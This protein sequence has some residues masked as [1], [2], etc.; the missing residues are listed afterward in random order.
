MKTFKS[1]T[2]LS[3]ALV[4]G[5]GA[6]ACSNDDTSDV[7]GAGGDNTGG[8]ASGSG[9][10]TNGT[11]GL[12]NLGGNGGEGGAD[13]GATILQLLSADSDYSLLVEAVTAAGLVEALSGNDLTVFAPN[14]AAMEELLDDLDLDSVSDLT[15]AQLRPIL[16]YHVLDH[17][18]SSTEAKSLAPGDGKGTSLG[19]KYELALD[20][21]DLL[22][23][24]ATV[25]MADIQATNGV[26]HHIDSVLLPSITDIVTTDPSLSG[27]KGWIVDADGATD[28]TPKL[29][30]VLDA[31]AEIDGPIDGKWTVFAPNNLAVSGLSTPPSGQD[32]T[33][34]LAYHTVTSL[35]AVTFMEALD[36]MNDSFETSFATHTVVVDGDGADTV[37]VSDENTTSDDAT[38]KVA[39]IYAANGIIHIIDE[40][41]LPV[42]GD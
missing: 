12:A 10:A 39:D 3:A 29:G 2:I 25:T 33:N 40:V 13:S 4:L 1:V 28:S 41:L 16:L 42:I 27:L 9:G 38:V 19:G 34:V 37:T 32:L 24:E 30:L 18:V 36:F 17:V 7:D 20:G 31:N 22:I 35:F 14:N 23:D 6:V 26:I 15:A 5:L 21:S 11:G 8:T